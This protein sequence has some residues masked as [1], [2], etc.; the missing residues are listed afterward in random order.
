MLFS[1]SAGFNWIG[2]ETVVVFHSGI[3]TYGIYSSYSFSYSLVD[4]RLLEVKWG[5]DSHGDIGA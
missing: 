5:V 2:E 4:L 1:G 3:L